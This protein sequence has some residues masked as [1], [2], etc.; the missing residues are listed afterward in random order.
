[1]S[2]WVSYE[3]RANDPTCMYFVLNNMFIGQIVLSGLIA[4]CF[5]FH[6]WV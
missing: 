4:C 5:G 3:V 1:M 2:Y 6:D